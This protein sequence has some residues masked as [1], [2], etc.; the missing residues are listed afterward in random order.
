MNEKMLAVEKRD[1]TGN[2]ALD[3]ANTAWWHASDQPHET[4]H[5]YGDLVRWSQLAG[6]LNEEETGLLLDEAE[7]HPDKAN[8]ILEEAISLREL[9]YTIFSA[10]AA[11]RPP[12]SVDLER[13]NAILSEAERHAK[14]IHTSTGF[15]WTW[16]S[17]RSYFD[18]VLWPITRSTAALLTSEDLDKLGECADD[19]G[20]GWLFIDTSR[21]RSRR[22]CSMESCGNRAK[23][24]R[25]YKRRVQKEKAP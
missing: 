10:V 2:L 13:F 9:I 18:R 22:W 15:E 3:F 8:E 12:G 17:D 23:A 1:E 4:I 19:R 7:R 24:R 16:D 20:C 6:L 5:S 25:H 21:N 11:D 14:L